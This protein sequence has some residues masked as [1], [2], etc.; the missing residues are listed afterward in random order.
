MY[1]SGIRCLIW[2]CALTYLFQHIYHPN[3][4]YTF[5]LSYI[6]SP[7]FDTIQLL[8][9]GFLHGDVY[10][11]LVNMIML[12]IF[13]SRIE[14]MFGAR[15]LILLFMFST[16]LGGIVETCSTGYNIYQI[17]GTLFPIYPETFFD[18]VALSMEY[19]TN[20][21]SELNKLVIGAS[22]GVFGCMVAFT[23]L[24]PTARLSFPFFPKLSISARLIILI[25]VI[26]E[27]Y[28]IVYSP[29]QNVAH[30]AHLGGAIGGLV[31]A[32]LWKRTIQKSKEIRENNVTRK[33]KA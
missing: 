31:I 22:A 18:Q 23:C 11:I 3:I 13:G 26:N 21:L 19:G 25:Y 12:I 14:I 17:S 6:G 32:L 20:Y 28:F 9:Y 1:L 10:H 4:D 27:I 2:V 30:Y 16:I 15:N 29:M 5:G 8:T 7:N 24:F 33:K